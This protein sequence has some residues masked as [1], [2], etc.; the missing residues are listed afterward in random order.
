MTADVSAT[1]ARGEP[2][3]YRLTM[4]LRAHRR[5]I[6][7]GL[8]G[9]GLVA[10]VVVALAGISWTWSAYP[11]PGA[12][13]GVEP[14]FRFDTPPGLLWSAGVVFVLVALLRWSIT[15][16]AL[17]QA[18]ERAGDITVV[19][20]VRFATEVPADVFP[21]DMMNADDDADAGPAD[22]LDSRRLALSRLAGE[23]LRAMLASTGRAPRTRWFQRRVTSTIEQ[24]PRAE[25]S[26]LT[27]SLTALIAPDTVFTRLSERRK[28]GDERASV[29][30]SRT[31]EG[32][33][34]LRDLM[35]V[36]VLSIP[37]G[38]LVGALSITVDG[39]PGR[40]LPTAEGRG[41]LTQMLQ[42]RIFDVAVPM[43]ESFR[44][45]LRAF[46]IHATRAIVSDRPVVAQTRQRWIAKAESVLQQ[47][48]AGTKG[49]WL[50]TL[51]NLAIANDIIFAIVPQGCAET[52]KM[53]ISYT[54][55]YR[56]RVSGPVDRFRR[57][58][59]IGPSEFKI[60]LHRVAESNSYHLDV[61]SDS[62]TYVE[63][64]S[65][66]FAAARSGDRAASGAQRSEVIHVSPLRGDA[67]AHVYWR[68]YRRDGLASGAGDPS[69]P[70]FYLRLRERPPG[71][72]GPAWMLSMWTT[73]LTWM[74][75]YF[76]P[77][78]F[79]S[80]TTG[81]SVWT[82]VILAAPAILTGW[83]LSR[84]TAD[85]MR[86]ISVSTFVLVSALGVIV[87]TLVAASAFT[88]SNVRMAE[89]GVGTLIVAP[90][91]EW[92]IL[93]AATLLHTL[94]CGLLFVGRGLRYASTINER[95]GE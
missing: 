93:M 33:S 16:R 14:V 82:T 11:P 52:I 61:V 50:T 10:L 15:D 47:A 20:A 56:E 27:A 48:K 12:V 21:G 77:V 78:L 37:K 9:V 8:S 90:H 70:Q 46:G 30:V 79:A 55:P 91:P 34:A 84:L 73:F 75:G 74:V 25:Q 13:A 60:D 44:E 7:T 65:V 54:E 86:I 42:D 22:Y 29:T 43:R 57:L 76:Y 23:H 69:P 62:N 40:T 39:R 53:E 83:L 51:A 89:W 49:E 68:D 67:Q 4:W 87:A 28:L 88:M 18:R 80:G 3:P 2:M 36:P 32:R 17:E 71:V 19:P 5:G 66:I 26:V 63:E 45:Q 85:S 35:L 81:S 31:I 41:L 59:G 94:A 24:P 64:A 38:S 6:R 72:L 1:V 95:A 92:L 58:V